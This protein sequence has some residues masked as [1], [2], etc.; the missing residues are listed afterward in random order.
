MYTSKNQGVRGFKFWFLLNFIKIRLM[1]MLIS[2]MFVLCLVSCA[3]IYVSHDYD[4]NTTFSKYKS[5]NFYE[6]M[7]SGLSEL[8]Q[9]R[10]IKA[11]EVKLGLMGFVKSDTPDVLIHFISSDYETAERNSV[12]IGIGGSGRRVGGG[13]SI[14]IPVGQHTIDR[15]I[16]L[17]FI[18]S[19]KGSTIWQSRSES[20]FDEDATPEAREARL[21]A[22]AEKMLQAYPIK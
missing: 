1:K 16:L 12:G 17:N 2:F 21:R 10:F 14:G 5:Y 11:L 22:I 19:S 3:S 9:K 8:D 15:V 7:A 13:I 4:K 18:D 20:R 6:D